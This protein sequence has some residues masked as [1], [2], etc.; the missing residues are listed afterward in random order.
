MRLGVGAPQVASDMVT[1]DVWETEASL[2]LSLSQRQNK[3]LCR[4]CEVRRPVGHR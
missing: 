3:S 1:D 2:G 4:S